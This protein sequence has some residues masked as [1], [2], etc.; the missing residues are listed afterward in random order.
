MALQ[1]LLSPKFISKGLQ[2]ILNS[3]DFDA[4]SSAVGSNLGHHRS[5]LLSA[6]DTFSSRMAMGRAGELQLLHIQGRGEVQLDR[7]QG[8][9]AAVLW[10]PL[11]GWSSERINGTALLA[12]PGMALFMQPGDSLLGQTS[13]HLEGLSILVPPDR[14]APETPRLLNLGAQHRV[15]IAAAREFAESLTRGAAQ[16]LVGAHALL[17]QLEIW[18]MSVLAQ[19]AGH[20]ERITAVRRRAYVSDAMDWMQTNLEQAF[21]VSQVAATIHVSVRTLQNAFLTETGQTPMA[22]A[23]RLRL[24]QLRQLL[25]NREAEQFPIA[26]LMAKVGLLAC[27]ATAADYRSYCGETPRQTRRRS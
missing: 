18:Q 13:H 17:D 5:D 26:E 21:D 15:L 16:G 14:I 4:W 11:Q 23:K 9:Q 2:P 7:M 24:R 27:G 22:M 6:A 20:G 19:I 1:S 10:L 3:G 25:L 8:E 12:E